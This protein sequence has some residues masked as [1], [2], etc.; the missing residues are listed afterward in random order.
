VL[1]SSYQFILI[2]LP[3]TYVAFLIA[4]RIGGWNAAIYV[5]AGA[6]FVFYGMWGTT[7]L[8]ILAA[9]LVFNYV[10]GSRIAG[11][12][13]TPKAARSA[14]L[15]GVAANLVLLGYLKYTNFFIDIANQAS[16]ASFNHIH[17]LV[18]V[19]VSFYTF[20]QIGYLIDAYNG[21]LVR[22]NFAR[23]VVF[24]AFFP[25]VTAGPLVMHREILDQLEER[26]GNAFNLRYLVT[27]LTMF[28]MGLF[29]KVALADTISPYADTVFNAVHAG[30]AVDLLTAWIG[31]AAYGLQL[32]FDFSGYSDMALGIAF[33]FG[34]RLPLNFDSPFKSTN[35]SE[36]WRR[37]HMTMTRFFT[38]Y[39]YS[40]LA[41]SGMRKAMAGG[42]GRVEKFVRT[43]AVPAIVTFL[44]AGVWHGAG[45]NMALY[46]L[47]HGCAIATYLGWREFSGRQ[48]P[49]TIAWAL[50]MGVVLSALVVFRSP[51]LATAGKILANMWGAGGLAGHPEAVAGLDIGRA[52]SMVV[53]Q[54]AA[55][56]LLPNTQQMLHLDWISSDEKPGSA[57]VEA[58][59]LTWRPAL[60]GAVMMALAYTVSFTTMGS[61][62]TFLYYQF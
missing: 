10:M 7:L 42:G 47:I 43:A 13:E 1:F 12:A 17:L 50:T 52:V 11:L 27:G 2:F 55:V 41:M 51:D 36:F 58:G 45:W 38:S 40:G 16:G 53:L 49:R 54:G 21:Q 23:Y 61:G 24:G 29:K 20:I 56:L 60:S 39:V 3:L 22:S 46:G 59:L 57:A 19:G 8:G 25:C 48:L 26:G 15:A 33:I 9:S 37:W 28:G 31:A 32:Y 44:V 5:L 34:I 62:T 6:S 18:P 35:I 30:G 4:H 14:M